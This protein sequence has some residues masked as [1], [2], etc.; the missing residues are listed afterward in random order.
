MVIEIEQKA[1]KFGRAWS[2]PNSRQHLLRKE[3]SK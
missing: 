2:P 1:E 3:A